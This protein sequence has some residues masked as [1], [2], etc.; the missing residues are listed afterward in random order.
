MKA[1]SII[2]LFVVLA[3]LG[4]TAGC[5]EKSSAFP[6]SL[7]TLATIHD[8]R[9]SF[10][11]RR[12]EIFVHL[13]D[14]FGD[15]HIHLLDYRGVSKEQALEILKAKQVELEKASAEPS[16]GANLAPRWRAWLVSSA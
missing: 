14:R 2:S 7:A 4:G 13:T 1:V 6:L 9:I 11:E 12:G 10:E 5:H 16:A 3:A 15:S 8:G